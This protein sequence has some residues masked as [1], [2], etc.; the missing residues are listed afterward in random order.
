MPDIG[1]RLGSCCKGYASSKARTPDNTL[2][3]RSNPKCTPRASER[4]RGKTSWDC[5]R[6]AEKTSRIRWAE[7]SVR[8]CSRQT[9]TPSK[10]AS[11]PRVPQ[12]PQQWSIE[13]ARRANARTLEEESQRR[14]VRLARYTSG[15]LTAR[16][17]CEEFRAAGVFVVSLVSSPGSGS[18]SGSGSEKT[19]FLETTLTQLQPRYRVRP[20]VI[21]ARILVWYRC[22]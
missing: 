12:A 19:A 18:G 20:P 22:R 15:D 21:W 14:C 2:V 3:N 4:G 1:T 9:V 16:A 11:K 13:S 5:V 17:L 7:P 10:P 8:L 6:P